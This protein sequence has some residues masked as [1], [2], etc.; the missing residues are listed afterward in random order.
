MRS[1]VTFFLLLFLLILTVLLATTQGQVSIPLHSF[2]D[3]LFHPDPTNQHTLIVWDLRLPRLASALAAGAAL[4][5]AGVLTQGVLRNPLAEP[6]T[7]GISAGAALG[8]S[9]ALLGAMGLGGLTLVT[10]LG[11]AAAAFVGALLALGGA[12]LLSWRSRGPSTLDL[13]L[14]GIVIATVC[15]ALTGLIKF[16]AGERVEG[17]VFWLMGHFQGA[18]WTTAAVASLGAVLALICGLWYGRHLD[19]LALGDRV[20]GTS[21]VHVVRLRIIVLV[22]AA[23]AAALA[24]AA[25]GIIAFIGLVIPHLMRLILGPAHRTLIIHSALAGAVVLA[26]ADTLA[27]MLPREVPV[28]ILTALIGGPVFAVLLRTTRRGGDNA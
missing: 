9:L 7:L 16:L 12:L 15:A 25:G 13:I 27:R 19:F 4:A 5:M 6:Y 24:V 28:G 26:G 18:T 11:P 10:A 8:A 22:A 3:L 14:A 20:A 1:T 21:G 17:I 2:F 23:F